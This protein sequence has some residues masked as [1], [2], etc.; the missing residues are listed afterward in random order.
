MEKLSRRFGVLKIK[1]RIFKSFCF[2]VAKIYRRDEWNAVERCRTSEP[3][4]LPTTHLV[5]DH[6]LTQPCS[7]FV[8]LINNNIIIFIVE[9]V[10]LMNNFQT[11][12]SEKMR[13]QQYMAQISC[14]YNDIYYGFAIGSSGLVFEGRGLDVAGER[15]KG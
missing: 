12:C 7:D 15:L 2:A 3:L 4:K 8:S 13:S 5:L 14:S 11:T 1:L 6:T 10:Q 9:S